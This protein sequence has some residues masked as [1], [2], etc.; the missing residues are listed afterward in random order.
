MLCVSFVKYE[1]WQAR[2]ILK[3]CEVVIFCDWF[4]LL[5]GKPR[6][7]NFSYCLETFTTKA[8]LVHGS[9]SLSGRSRDIGPLHS[10][11]NR[12]LLL[13]RPCY[14]LDNLLLH[15]FS[16]I[17][18]LLRQ[19]ISSS[20]SQVLVYQSIFGSEFCS[21]HRALRVYI[22]KAHPWPALLRTSSS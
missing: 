2:H 10:F 11:P 14:L 13:S 18:Y 20:I 6:R 8:K 9:K 17:H 4:G 12:L 21:G 7:D 15:L 5:Q 19:Y 3:D 1:S 16:S 22:T